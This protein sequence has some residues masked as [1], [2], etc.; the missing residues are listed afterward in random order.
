MSMP[1]IGST[2]QG[3]SI[4]HMS[5]DEVG[6]QMEIPGATIRQRLNFG[7]ATGYGKISVEYFTLAAGVDTTPLFQGLEG[8]LCQSPHWRSEER[9]VGKECRSRWSRYHEKR[10]R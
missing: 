9:R 5:K 10:K 3:A 8:N 4:M 6:V 1:F 2:T 7:D